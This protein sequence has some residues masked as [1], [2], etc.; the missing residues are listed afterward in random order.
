MPD[1]NYNLRL[2]CYDSPSNGLA[3]SETLTNPVAI[4]NGVLQTP[5]GFDPSAFSGP[6]PYLDIAIQETNGTFTELGS[7]LAFQPVPQ[8]YYAGFAGSVATVAGQAVTTINGMTDDL[9]LVAGNNVSLTTGSNSVIINAGGTQGPT[10]PQ[11]PQGLQGL[12]GPQGQTGPAG[13]QGPQG[14]SGV[15]TNA[16]LLLGNGGTVPGPNFLGTTD[17]QPLEMHVNGQRVMRMEPTATVPNIIGGYSG[18]V[19][20][21]GVVGATIAGGG[22]GGLINRIRSM[23]GAIGGGSAN[24]IQSNAN[25]STIGGGETNTIGGNANYA[26]IAGGMGNSVSG[27]YGAIPGGQHNVANGAYSFA[28]GQQAQA[29]HDGTFVWADDSTSSPYVSTGNNQFCVRAQGGVRLDNSTSMAFGNQ[30]RQMLELYRDPTSTYV[31]GIGVQNATLYTR[32]AANG[33]FAWFQGGVHNDNTANPGGGQTLMTLT[34]SGLTVNG[35]FASSSDRNLKENFQS[36]DA[37]AV[38]DKVA[39]LPISKWNYKQDCG[40]EHI[41]PMAQDFYAA[42]SVGPDER[43][44]TTIDENGVSLAAIQGLNRKVEEQRSELEAKE[45]RWKAQQSQIA[46]LVERLAALEQKLDDSQPK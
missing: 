15:A 13:P 17:N 26:T 36:V 30:T 39:A 6:P 33:G 46:Q 4:L 5:L 35:T 3:V 31:Y 16:W 20:D 42:F 28:A 37:G 32:T 2:T 23:Q 18:N 34:S 27:Q 38:L 9:Q 22:A 7:R 24:L 14:P 10:G 21:A 40:T 19:A 29:L 43:H 25:S 41:G 45:V 1:G 11:G 44:I 12:Q 8:A